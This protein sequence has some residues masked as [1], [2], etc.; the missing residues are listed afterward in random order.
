MLQK[1]SS[2]RAYTVSLWIFILDREEISLS[3]GIVN[4]LPVAFFDLALE[5]SY[6]NPLRS[7]FVN[8]YQRAI[9]PAKLALP[10]WHSFSTIPIDCGPISL[11]FESWVLRNLESSVVCSLYNYRMETI[12]PTITVL[13]KVWSLNPC[14]SLTSSHFSRELYLLVL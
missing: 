11:S 8:R 5:H 12:K 3:Q 10:F 7:R 4:R 13:L 6:V 2:L 1:F 9:V 14:C